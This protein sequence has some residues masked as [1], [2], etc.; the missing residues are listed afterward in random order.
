MNF[1]LQIL[2]EQVRIIEVL[3]ERIENLTREISK[4]NQNMEIFK[5]K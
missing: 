5:T 4:L 2:E 3:S 1:Y